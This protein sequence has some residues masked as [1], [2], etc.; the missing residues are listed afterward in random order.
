MPFFS[1]S[2]NTEI[3]IRQTNTNA[4]KYKISNLTS[5]YVEILLTDRKI[6][7]NHTPDLPV[8]SMTVS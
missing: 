4:E 2:K 6:T 5:E 8:N 1:K 7:H 3:K